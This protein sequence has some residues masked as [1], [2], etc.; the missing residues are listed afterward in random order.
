MS[1]ELDQILVWFGEAK[2][3]G[4]I[5]ALEQVWSPA[6]TLA[7]TRYKVRL[8]SGDTRVLLHREVAGFL[9]GLGR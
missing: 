8:N 6:N 9:S 1:K 5:L 4:K 7:D 2:R 3:V